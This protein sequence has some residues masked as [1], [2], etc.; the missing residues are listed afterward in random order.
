MLLVYRKSDGRVIINSG[1]NSFLPDGPPFETEV[2][3]AILAA[4][5]QTADYASVRLNDQADGDQVQA[6]LAGGACYVLTDQAGNPTGL[7]LYAHIGANAN[8]NPAGVNQ[9]VN[10]T[11]LLPADTPDPTVTFQ[12]QGGAAYLEPIAAGQ[13]AH[14][15]AFATPGRYSLLVSSDHHGT[16]WLEVTVQ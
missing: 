11:A 10:V 4:G 6:I 8:P 9:S 16:T 2:Q 13:A 12:V 1:T 5:G 7:Q 14:T 3:N 15:F